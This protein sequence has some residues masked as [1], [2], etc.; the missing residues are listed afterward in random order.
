M[1]KEKKDATLLVRMPPEL[2]DAFMRACEARDESAAQAIRAMVRQ[3]VK[4]YMES[5]GNQ[6]SLKV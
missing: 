1:A 4:D 3:Y 2:K 6:P 5:G